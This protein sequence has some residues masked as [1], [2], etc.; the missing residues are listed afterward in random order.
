MLVSP[1][2]LCQTTHSQI[3]WWPCT[4]VTIGDFTFLWRQG[5]HHLNIWVDFHQSSKRLNV[6]SLFLEKFRSDYKAH[7]L[8]PHASL[9]TVLH[10]SHPIKAG[11]TLQIITQWWLSPRR[12]LVPWFSHC[13]RQDHRRTGWKFVGFHTQH[14]HCSQL[15]KCWWQGHPFT[16]SHLCLKISCIIKL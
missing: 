3:T 15:P 9:N 10:Q 5:L 1:I 11:V 4:E 2:P 13:W 6:L 8:N 16:K 14:L 7:F 12:Y